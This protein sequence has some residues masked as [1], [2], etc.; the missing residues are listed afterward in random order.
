MPPFHA[1]QPHIFGWPFCYLYWYFS[2]FIPSHSSYYSAAVHTCEFGIQCV[3]SS[4]YFVYN[5]L[6][7]CVPTWDLKH[8][9]GQPCKCVGFSAG[10]FRCC[11]RGRKDESFSLIHKD[12]NTSHTLDRQITEPETGKADGHYYSNAIQILC[13][14]VTT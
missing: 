5:I 6:S 2:F 10:L 1:W 7:R 3:Y 12:D 14:H 9:C 8:P 4:L 11:R 13:L